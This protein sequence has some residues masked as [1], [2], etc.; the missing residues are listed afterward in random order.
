M[1]KSFKIIILSLL[2][3][4]IAFGIYYF[5]TKNGKGNEHSSSIHEEYVCPMHSN[6]VS[7]MPGSCPICGMPLEKTSSETVPLTDADLAVLV[8]PTD[9]FIVGNYTTTLPLDTALAQNITL[10]GVVKYDLNSSVSI[11]A[12]VDGRIEK[13]YIKYKFQKISKGQKLFDIYSPELLTEQKNYLYLIQNDAQNKA[14]IQAAKQKLLLLGMSQKQITNLNANSSPI[15]TVFSPADGVV[16]ETKDMGMLSTMSAD[17]TTSP[18][19][20]NEGSYIQKNSNVFSLLSTNRVWGIFNLLPT[21]SSLVGKGHLIT[22]QSE[23]EN[24]TEIKAKVDFIET[25]LSAGEKTN[26]IRV[27]LNNKFNALPIGVRLTGIIQ[28]KASKSLYIKRESVV[29]IGN[30]QI[31][32]QKI[33]NGF[34]AIKIETGISINDFVQVLSGINAN[35]EIAQNAQFLTDSESFIKIN[36]L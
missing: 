25:Q 7:S 28:L 33:G 31:V 10:P 1:K 27:Y 6:I 17:Y 24:S 15:I 13:M 9:K 18:L 36:K 34:K 20:I 12:R 23:I 2:S 19:A 5:F 8:Q 29:S 4:G 11:S 30:Q 14:I 16:V 3:I 21:Q 26:R 22:I 35:T 32:F